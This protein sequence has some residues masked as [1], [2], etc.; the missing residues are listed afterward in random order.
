VE[1][2]DEIA[3]RQLAVNLRGVIIG[4]KLAIPLMQKAGGGR[5]VNIASLAGKVPSP[6]GATYSATK[7]AVV[8]LSESLYEELLDTNVGVTL[9]MPGVI[10]TELTAGLKESATVK[11]VPPADVA[12]GIVEGI[13]KERFEV[14]V[15]KSLGRTYK[16]TQFLPR[17]M[18]RAI[19]KGMKADKL[20]IDIDPEERKVYEKRTTG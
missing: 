5:L 4:S 11:K 18:R 12:A 19:A 6:G 7:W 13:R 8:G 20:L 2:G 3:D 16:V 15:P 14:F 17:G 1:E 10:D 9:V